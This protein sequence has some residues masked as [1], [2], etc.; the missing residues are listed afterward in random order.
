MLELSKNPMDLL[1]ELLSDQQGV[2]YEYTPIDPKNEETKKAFWR[3][4]LQIFSRV[5]SEKSGKIEYRIII[6]CRCFII[7]WLPD[8]NLWY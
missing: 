2:P 7:F 5:C 8:M 4:R 3:L 6:T 1:I